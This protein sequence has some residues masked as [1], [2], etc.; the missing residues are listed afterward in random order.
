MMVEKEHLLGI[1]DAYKI[2]SGTAL[3]VTVSNRVFGDGKKLAALRGEADITL[4]RFN[5]AM[6]WFATNWPEGSAR[7]AVLAVYAAAPAAEPREDAA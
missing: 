5:M 4:G 3:D 7:P 1:A 6:R 2:A